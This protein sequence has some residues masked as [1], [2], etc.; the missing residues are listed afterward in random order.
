M[1]NATFPEVAVPGKGQLYARLVTS[2][3]NIVVRL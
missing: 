2:L 1:P 3:G